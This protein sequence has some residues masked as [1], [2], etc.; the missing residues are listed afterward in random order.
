MVKYCYGSDDMKKR[1]VELVTEWKYTWPMWLLMLLYMI[2]AIARR[3]YFT[4]WALPLGAIIV[5]SS[6]LLASGRWYGCFVGSV[7]GTFCIWEYYDKIR[8]FEKVVFDER[9]LGFVIIAYYLFMGWLCYR[10]NKK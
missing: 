5:C 6:L 7:Y 2:T 1:F 3:M 9:V 4:E 10:E 8:N